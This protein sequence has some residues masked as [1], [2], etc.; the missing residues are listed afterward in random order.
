MNQNSMIYVHI[1]FCIRKCNYCDFLSFNAS[2][3]VIQEYIDA[4][5]LEIKAW[6]GKEKDLEEGKE[7]DDGGGRK[8]P[9]ERWRGR[10]ME[11]ERNRGKVHTKK[12]E[13]KE[14]RQYRF[15]YLFPSS[16]SLTALSPLISLCLPTFHYLPTHPHLHTVTAL[17]FHDE[18]S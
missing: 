10:K 4:L 8:R 18:S 2:T 11:E 17:L 3:Q 12:K 7:D 14:E 15:M 6:K 16:L 13:Q 1:P 9:R 5:C